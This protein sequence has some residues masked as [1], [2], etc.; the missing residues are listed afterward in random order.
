MRSGSNKGQRFVFA[1]RLPACQQSVDRTLQCARA[2][3]RRG[4]V[5]GSAGTEAG[6]GERRG[7]E[8][9]RERE[10]GGEGRTGRVRSE[11]ATDRFGS[12]KPFQ[13]NWKAAACCAPAAYGE[14]AAL[15]PERAPT[16]QQA[17]VA[18]VVTVSQSRKE[19]R[20]RETTTLQLGYQS[21]LSLFNSL[22]HQIDFEPVCLNTRTL[23]PCT[24]IVDSVRRKERTFPQLGSFCVFF[25]FV[26]EQL[27][28]FFF[29]FFCVFLCLG[30][31]CLSSFFKRCSSELGSALSRTME[32][33][34]EPGRYWRHLSPPGESSLPPGRCGSP[35]SFSPPLCVPW[36]SSSHLPRRAAGRGGGTARGGSRRS[37][38]RSLTSSS[39]PTWPR[40]PLEP[41]GDPRARLRATPSALKNWRRITTQILS[42][43]MRKTRAPTGSW[44]R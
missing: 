38:S 44:H 34:T 24:L 3:P 11:V 35:S 30:G 20:G 6:E 13:F 28:T 40:R 4:G 22:T 21:P 31:A 5:G 43:R 2:V 42:S 41:A 12:L 36:S 23:Q 19:K 29:F 16:K 37:S 39:A 9:E 10:R 14:G 26:L 32:S 1:A 15:N 27:K 25:C 8:R 33:G 7:E 17:T 18:D